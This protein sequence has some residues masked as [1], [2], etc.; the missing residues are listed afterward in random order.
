MR[1]L[2]LVVPF[3]LL[4]CSASG[5]EDT[6]HGPVFDDLDA[7]DGSLAA[8]DG[9]ARDAAAPLD[10]TSDA[11]VTTDTGLG[12]AGG[13]VA[14]VEASVDAG[15]A[16]ACAALTALLAGSPSSL[17][18]AVSVG[19]G[20]FASSPLTGS[21]AS[22]PAIAPLGGAFQGLLRASGNALDAVSYAAP[23]WS[24]PAPLSGGPRAPDAPA[25]AA[26]GA[27]LHAVYLSTGNL[28]FHATW[29]GTAWDSGSDPVKP[30]NDAGPQSFGPA[31]PSAAGLA[32]EFVLAYQGNDNHVY[33]QS[34]TSAGG[35][36]S[37]V[38]IGSDTLPSGPATSPPVIA[39]MDSGAKDLVVV[40]ESAADTKLYS[41]ARDASSKQWSGPTLVNA[42][43]FTHEAA[44]L[45]PMAGGRAI[46]A[47]RGTDGLGYTS[48]FDASA[49]A[50]TA[51]VPLVAG[52]N[53]PVASAPS[54]APGNCG[55]DAVAAAVSNGGVIVARY[56]GGAW[57][58]PV[59]VAGIS[60]AQFVGVATG[61]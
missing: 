21:L 2:V 50:W 55:D 39:A 53:P 19:G 46:V 47:W 9:G 16:A 17:A 10:A 52:T 23:S 33:A 30:A 57:R 12:D 61:P 40:Y 1:R 25:I 28:Y 27:S 56:A 15:D 3:L 6:T 49:G 11:F 31:R 35:W 58:A 14:P 41:F 13:D 43:A 26:V 22:A 51:P 18:G 8:H 38:K 37:A 4:G 45:A 32:S 42:T 20:A 29:N 24:A 54:L 5:T 36:A 59:T 34:W 48:A 7:S 60:G 44:T